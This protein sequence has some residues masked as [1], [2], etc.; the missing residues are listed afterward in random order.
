MDPL[1]H[2]LT[3][4]ALVRAVS[5]RPAKGIALLVV[6]AGVAPDLDVLSNLAGP[7]AGLWF[8]GAVTHSVL[9][10][11]A[12]AALLAFSFR[13][14]E[15]KRPGDGHS[16][17]SAFGWATLGAA[18]HLLLDLTNSYGLA[19]LWPFR[20]TRTAWNF[21]LLL[22]PILLSVLLFTLLLPGL[23]RLISEEIGA[24]TEGRAG[25]GWATAALA[26][27][28]V[29]CAARFF[30][31]ER[32]VTL[33]GAS[34]YHDRAPLHTGA[35]PD[36]ANPFHWLGVVETDVSIEEVEVPVSPGAEFNPDRSRTYYKPEASPALDAARSAPAA[37]RFLALARF[38][39]ASI[40]RTAEG[41]SVTFRDV[42]FS[43]LRDGR[44]YYFAGVD[45]D[46]QGRV[47][48]EEL[49]YRRERLR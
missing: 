1:T 29:F 45:L 49:G 34:R 13:A 25:R 27:L 26:F 7:S 18:V 22:D 48:Q 40:E 21:T 16:F 5:P 33:L 47:V 19:L 11:A 41:F 37:A 38:P 15:R 42:G 31:H 12:L 36:S 3:S 44:G 30:L 2:A 39:S 8:G 6:A 24:H 17:L 23:F 9:G 35:F 4:Y 43:P 32:A 28:A 10:A 46:P 20:M 14:W